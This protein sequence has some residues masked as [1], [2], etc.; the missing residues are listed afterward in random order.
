M[1][2]GL[3]TDADEEE[4]KAY[5]NERVHADLLGVSIAYDFRHQQSE[6][7]RLLA[8][9]LEEKELKYRRLQAQEFGNVDEMNQI[10]GHKAQEANV[11][12]MLRSLK[13]SGTA[14]LVF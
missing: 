9:H 10:D 5:F 6:V 7:T 2:T 12:Q 13:G 1:V 11:T 14:F 4:I 8:M 3:P